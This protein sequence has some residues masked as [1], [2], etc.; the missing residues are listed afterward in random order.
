MIFWCENG[1]SQHDP[2]Q[3]IFGFGTGAIKEKCG[4]AKPP[5]WRIED[6]RVVERSTRQGKLC[7]VGVMPVISVRRKGCIFFD[8]DELA[9][10]SRRW[11][12]HGCDFQP[13]RVR[14]AGVRGQT[15]KNE[16]KRSR[17]NPYDFHGD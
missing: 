2:I 6:A 12:R 7:S 11:R 9:R 4:A 10:G 1:L 3:S 5:D 8:R 16:Q 14:Y 13:G 15:E 17:A